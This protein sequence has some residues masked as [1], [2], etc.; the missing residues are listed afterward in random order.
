MPLRAA[1]KKSAGPAFLF[2]RAE[3]EMSQAAE[4]LKCGRV[5]SA[6]VDPYR[7][8]QG[9]NP[10]PDTGI[11]YYNI[12]HSFLFP[13]GLRLCG[14]FLCPVINILDLGKIRT[15]SEAFTPLNS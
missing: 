12:D 2:E 14:L 9:K 5:P 10:A 4:D 8:E 1:I 15:D 7:D 3:A 11:F 6:P 13:P